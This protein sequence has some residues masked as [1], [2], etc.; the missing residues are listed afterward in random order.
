MIK[1]FKKKEKNQERLKKPSDKKVY[2]PKKINQKSA[3]LIFGFLLI[4][5]IL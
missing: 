3:N 1:A 5:F 4:G 2:T